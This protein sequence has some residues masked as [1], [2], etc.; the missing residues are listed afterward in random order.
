MVDALLLNGPVGVGKSAAAYELAST[1]TI[2][3]ALIDVD[4][5]RRLWPTPHGDP[6]THAVAVANLRSLSENY[7]A[8]GAERVILA[9]VVE[10]ASAL[11]EYRAA[12][13]VESL[14]AIRLTADESTV[15]RRLEARHSEDAAG[16]AWHV[17]RAAELA[18][19]LERAGLDEV[20]I[21]STDLD[22]A[23][24]ASAVRVA[25]GWG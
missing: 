23:G 2:P 18:G 1:A 13:G 7:R 15:R 21:D 10:E 11:E 4:E 12:L 19:I 3:T 16:L 20:V 6:F 24:V 25:A 5:V 22:A 17:A 9:G 8:A 14:L